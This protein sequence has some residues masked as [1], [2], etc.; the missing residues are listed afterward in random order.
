QARTA[1]QRTFLPGAEGDAQ[2]DVAA[3]AFLAYE[4]S[5]TAGG[6][7]DATLAVL[8]VVASQALSITN[9]KAPPALQEFLETVRSYCPP[10]RLQGRRRPL[11]RELDKLH[12][13]FTTAVLEGNP[14]LKRDASA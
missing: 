14:D 6:C 5:L 4:K 8:A 10:I 2:D 3:P 1:A 11:G 7:L 13:T 12:T 9:R